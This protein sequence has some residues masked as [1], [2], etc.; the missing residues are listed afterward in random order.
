MNSQKSLINTIPLV[1]FE[2]VFSQLISNKS[3][4]FGYFYGGYDKNGNS[5]CGDCVE[6]RPIIEEASKLLESQNKVLFLKFPVDDRLEWKKSNF[7]FRTHPKVK[8]DRVPTLIYYQNGVEFGR[9]IEGE[10]FDQK[11]VEDFIKQSLE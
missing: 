2:S 6:A 8:L 10:L 1:D 7:V 11:N 4:F 9:L 5:W 3:T